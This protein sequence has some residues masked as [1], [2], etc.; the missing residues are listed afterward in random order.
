MTHERDASPAQSG[1][2]PTGFW[3]GITLGRLVLGVVTER[4]GERWAVVLYLGLSLAFQLIFWL[5]PS[6]ITSAVAVSFI[7]FFTG[8]LFPA[9]IVVAAKLLPKH[10][11]TAGIGI[12]SAFAGS[13]AAV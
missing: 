1:L 3:L 5:V 11:H 7:G 2:V 4:L 8:P 6:F 10:L 9:A 12:A 13:G